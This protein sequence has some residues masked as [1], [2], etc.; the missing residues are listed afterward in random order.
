MTK[1]LSMINKL[2]PAL[3]S[4]ISGIM[5][6]IGVFKKKHDPAKIETNSRDEVREL[7]E[8]NKSKKEEDWDIVRSGQDD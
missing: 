4:I 6:L 8:H 3:P 2:I 1:I 7:L 5:T